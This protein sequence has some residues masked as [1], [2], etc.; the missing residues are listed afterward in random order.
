MNPMKIAGSLFFFILGILVLQSCAPAGSATYS[1]KNTYT[2]KQLKE[3]ASVMEEILRK[4][5]PSLN[6]YASSSE[7]DSAFSQ[8]YKQLDTP[9][10]ETAFRNVLNQTAGVIRCGHTSVRPSK[11]HNWYMLW[12]PPQGFPLGLKVMDDST[13]L[14]T[15]NLYRTDSILTRGVQIIS[16]NQ[17]SARYLIDTLSSLIPIDGYARGFSDQNLSNLFSRFYNNLFPNDSTYRI[18]FKNNNGIIQNI[19]RAAYT[20]AGDTLSSTTPS[21]PSAKKT[22]SRIKPKRGIPKSTYRSLM[23][24]S[25]ERYAVLRIN[26]FSQELKRSFIRRSFKKL[27]KDSIPALIIDL[28]IN[29]GGLISSSLLL[30][31]MIHQEPFRYA[32]SIVSPYQKIRGEGRVTKRFISNLGMFFLSKK[33]KTGGYRFRYFQKELYKPHRLRFKGTIY[34]LTGGYSFSATS[35]LLSSIKGASNVVIVGEESGGGYYGNNGGFIPDIVL[36]NTKIRVRLPLYRIVNN[37]LLPF[38]GKGVP[39]DIE[40]KPTFE[41]IRKNE[42]PKM[43]KA[44]ELILS[45]GE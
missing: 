10:T 16:I 18:V 26:T 6:W 41:D 39:P 14:I 28:R 4:N 2:P 33:N 24:E 5:H 38:N 9:L 25:Q 40:I 31:K 7:I 35:M 22:K 29:G 15:S 1:P 45:S 36:P 44:V 8:L 34:V 37:H 27:K 43:K 17:F 20:K 13:L 21:A 42:D 12:Q 11:K 3:D 32:D 30:A 23:I 19:Q